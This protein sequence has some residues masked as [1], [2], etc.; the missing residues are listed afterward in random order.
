MLRKADAFDEHLHLI[1][2]PIFHLIKRKVLMENFQPVLVAKLLRDKQAALHSGI[3]ALQH[4]VYVY[5]YAL[6]EVV[7][8]TE[9]VR[10]CYLLEKTR[11][12]H[13]L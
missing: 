3:L 4:P 7:K 12:F 11:H 5:I 9:L 1:K 6:N 10:H 13:L 8:L 2:S